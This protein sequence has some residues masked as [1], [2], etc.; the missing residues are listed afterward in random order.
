MTN[1]IT[2]TRITIEQ[3]N[4]KYS[5]RTKKFT[6]NFVNTLT[7][8]SSWATLTDTLKLVF[9]KNIY[10]VDERGKKVNW[11]GKNIIADKQ[12][13]LILRG[14]K[15]TVSLGYI[16]QKE[17]SPV[18]QMNSEFTGY[19]TKVVNRSPLQIEAEDN[20]YMLKQIKA[21]NKVFPSASYDLQKIM[22]EL[23]KDT[24]FKVV[25][26][27]ADN[28][29]STSIGSFRTHNETVAQVLE[30]LRR[31]YHIESYFRGDELR[32][33]GIVYYPQDCI[34]HTF[35]F[36]E[37]IISDQLEYRRKDDVRIG[38]KAYSIHGEEQ[39]EYN[40][41]G[42]K[43]Y[44]QKRLETTVGDM[45]GEIRTLYFL[46]VP[47]VEQLKVKAQ[48]K[49]NRLYYEGFHGSFT[50]FGLPSV[51]HGDATVLIDTM[52]PE[53]QG[54]YLIKQVEKTMSKNNGFKQT[55]TIDIR[56]DTLT[57]GEIQLGL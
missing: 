40:V 39:S 38:V 53:R 50:T 1:L 31:D 5:G 27:T 30:R 41:Y 2:Q 46:D 11:E 16:Y 28:T 54:T 9:P 17:G 15:I 3:S 52:I 29:V 23:L 42:H 51:K 10:F 55:I 36:Q 22:T 45:D 14:D 48:E 18:L 57:Q 56:T 26:S 24:P 19:I 34:K 33:S 37:N 49:L 7:I 43:N 44:K 25:S 35:K 21:P 20:M 13:P 12:D 6:F 4:A 8:V 32:C 47:T